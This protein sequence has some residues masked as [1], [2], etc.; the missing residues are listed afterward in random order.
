MTPRSRP[1]RKRPS[2]P[3]RSTCSWRSKHRPL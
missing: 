2:R 1:S 3:S